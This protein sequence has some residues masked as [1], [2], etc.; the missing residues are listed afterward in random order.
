MPDPSHTASSASS[1][2]G[3]SQIGVETQI[4]M[5]PSL[6]V[7]AKKGIVSCDCRVTTRGPPDLGAI[8]GVEQ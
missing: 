1:P 3:S 8:S 7:A 5:L 6:R 2:F 4:L